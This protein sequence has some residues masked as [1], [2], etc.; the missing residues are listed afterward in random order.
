M[1]E[2]FFLLHILSKCF[3]ELVF[4]STN[5]IYWHWSIHEEIYVPPFLYHNNLKIPCW[6]WETPET[7]V[8]YKVD[9]QLLYCLFISD[10]IRLICLNMPF[11]CL[12]SIVWLQR[13]YGCVTVNIMLEVFFLLHIL[14]KF[15][16]DLVFKSTNLIYWHCW[17]CICR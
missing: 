7:I 8:K 10:G 6:L 11:F 1:L 14:S 5:L 13:I 17:L 2:V 3:C 16:C 15:F 9:A 4:E 12:F